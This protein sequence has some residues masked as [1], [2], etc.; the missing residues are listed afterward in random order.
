M[1]Q[2]PGGGEGRDRNMAA[3]LQRGAAH[4]SLSYLDAGGIRRAAQEPRGGGLP[5]DGA[6]R[7]GMG[8]LRAPPRRATFRK[9][10][11]KAETTAVV[12]SINVVRKN[13][14]GQISIITSI[15]WPL[16]HLLLNSPHTTGARRITRPML[17]VEPPRAQ[18]PQI[19]FELAFYWRSESDDHSTPLPPEDASGRLTGTIKA[20]LRCFS[21]HDLR[22]SSAVVGRAQD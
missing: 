18:Q 2:K 16:H 22:D 21:G 17:R 8:S 19:A 3:A 1:V 12:S 14:A 20:M 13:G 10:Q 6:D 5:G 11:Q 7:C 9:G 15:P 4:S